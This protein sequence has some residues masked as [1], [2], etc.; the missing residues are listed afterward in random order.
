[1]LIIG[2]SNGKTCE[3]SLVFV[4]LNELGG[5]VEVVFRHWP[6][7]SDNAFSLHFI[8]TTMHSWN[9]PEQCC[10]DLPSSFP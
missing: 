2:L 4:E 6:W 8:P 3:P 7:V 9:S 10:L 1:V 5:T